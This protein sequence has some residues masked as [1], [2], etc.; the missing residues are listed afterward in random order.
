MNTASRNQIDAIKNDVVSK[1]ASVFG[2]DPSEA[3]VWSLYAAVALTVRDHAAQ[4]RLSMRRSGKEIGKRVYYLSLEFL[5]G[6]LL[7]D[8]LSNLGLTA[9][10]RAA[11][12][13]LGVDI[14]QLI[15][16]EPDAALGNGGLGRLAACFMDSMSTLGIRGMGYGI[17]YEH[18]LF[19]QIIVGGGQQERPE[20]WLALGN[21]WEIVQPE[22]FYPV[23]FGG[24]IQGSTMPGEPIW[25]PAETIEA[26]AFDTHIVGWRGA[27]VNLLRLWSARAPEPLQL[28]VFNQGDHLRA[29]SAQVAAQSISKVLYPT[30]TT[31][32]GQELR[33]CQE[34]FFVSSSLQDI[35]QRHTDEHGDVR[36]FADYAAI[37]LNDTHPSLAVAELMRIFIDV[38]GMA[39]DDA[40]NITVSALS[41][42][43]HTLLPEALETWP[44]PLVERLLPRHLDIIYRI[45]AQHLEHAIAHHS[46]AANNL[47]EISIIDEQHGRRL[48]M[49][50]LAFIGSRRV[51]GV[52]VLHTD[53]M[54]K[55]VFFPLHKIYPDRIVNKTNGITFRRW[56]SEANPALTKLLISVCG[57]R[58][59]E[60]SSGLHALRSRASDASLQEQF[61]KIKRASKEALSNLIRQQLHIRVDPGAMFDVQIKRI[62]EYKRQLLN[63]LEA[64]SL[65]RAIRAQPTL[66]WVPRVK[67]FSGKAAASYEQA[68]LIIKL[69]H[70]VA[71]VINNDP[72]VRGLLKIVFLPDYNVS[73][74]QTIIP[75]ADLSEQISTAG[76]EASG[77]G[78]M[79]LA[80]NGALTVGT[81]DGANVEIQEHVGE[82]NIFIFGLL[83]NE[84]EDRRRRGLDAGLAI[85]LSPHL[86]GALDALTDDAFCAG[87]AELFS[88]LADAVRYSDY[89][90]IAADFDSYF[91]TQRRIDSLWLSTAGW[92]RTALLNIG[93][94]GWFSSDRTISEYAADI[95]NVPYELPGAERGEANRRANVG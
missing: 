65:Y 89:Y 12:T 38:H 39:W 20:R 56:L 79:K 7:S 3:S 81:L 85:A 55:T 93:G 87:D 4:R 72:E 27:H 43:N 19:K 31:P 73:L 6:R 34:Y 13:E 78:N 80:V 83:A 9:A 11:L 86:G 14:N 26:A 66:N 45:N 22:I 67:I 18:G 36:T 76:M 95:W 71:D 1:L 94:M 74:A 50:H 16:A 59:L 35:V 41:Y 2:R 92:A 23:H 70:N 40:W 69:I 82:N 54:R 33:F 60:D 24:S 15:A 68:K 64:V 30:D 91:E 51:N 29:Q 5:I 47:A 42:T 44:V 62:H 37:Q 28:D 49:G 61:S 10:F 75:A 8:T 53:L 17:R 21:P 58:I 90:M 25:K 57:D 48:R 84:V 77:T 88:P 63:V 32:A 52:S 46:E